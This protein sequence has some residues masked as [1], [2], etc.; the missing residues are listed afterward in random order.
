[1]PRHKLAK[2]NYRLRRRGQVWVIDWTDEIS[3]RTRSVSTGAEKR[4]AAEIWRD[5]WIAGRQQPL[6]PSQP[7]ISDILDGYLADRRPRVAAFATLVYAS[8]S[9]R[10]HVGNLEPRMLAR[11]AYLDRRVR[12]KVS[13]GTIRREVS[14]LRAA[15]AWAQ[16][17]AWIDT[18]PYVEMPPRPAPRDRWLTKEE[19]DRLI[20]SASSPHMRLFVAL[21]YHT[22]ARAGAIL[23]LEWD[24]VD[25]ERKLITYDRPGRQATKKR[26]AVVPIN[27]VALAELQSARMVAV[28]DHV[29]EFRGKPVA[30]IKTGF[31]AACRR[32]GIAECSPHV[33]RH[34]SATHLVMAGIP[35]IEIARMLGDTVAMVEQVYGKHSPDFLRSAADALAGNVSATLSDLSRAPQGNPR[36]QTA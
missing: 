35:M 24:R 31:R 15:L 28:S 17:E 29:I 33:L 34:S 21:A 3:G 13:D 4:A 22:A 30:S 23:D 32:A 10:R 19:V 5:Q 2:P 14:A 7:R 6:P 36:R 20:R 11:R 16:R 25:L 8:A 1:M 12:D 18:A 26:R 27:T 9:I